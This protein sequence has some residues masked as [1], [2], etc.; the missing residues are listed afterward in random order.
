MGFDFVVEY[1]RGRENVV[2]DALS[3]KVEEVDGQSIKGQPILLALS[4]PTPDWLEAIREENASNPK[5]S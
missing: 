5:V 4:Q 2:A 1:K 3:R